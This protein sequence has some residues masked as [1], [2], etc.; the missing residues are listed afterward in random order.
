MKNT[1][2][3]GCTVGLL[4]AVA[5]PLV[6]Q[7]DPDG[8]KR[9]EVDFQAVSIGRGIADL[10]VMQNGKKMP[11]YVPSFSLSSPIHYQGA[12]DLHFIQT[13]VGAGGSQEITVASATVPPQEKKVWILFTPLA[14]SPGKYS[15]QV[16]PCAEVASLATSA[17]IY[18]LSNRDIALE[19]NGTAYRVKAGGSIGVPLR[20][21][22][23]ALFIPRV[24]KIADD[25]ADICR[26]TYT[27][28]EGGRLTLLLMNE[29]V[30]QSAAS[31]SLVIIP[32]AENAQ[33]P[34]T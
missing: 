26:E 29:S 18:N 8:G 2:L 10:G 21:G 11:F 24:H 16:I 14:L 25:E 27:A 12:P 13:Q 4:C 19:L 3:R 17:R 34:G 15:T 31:E 33:P 30:A 23:V 7:P 5:A 6:A 28:P 1:L 20:K 9:V 22:K 32:L